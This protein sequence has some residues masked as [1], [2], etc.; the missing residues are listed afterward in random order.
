MRGLNASSRGV[1]T[2]ILSCIFD[3]LLWA[4]AF[5]FLFQMHPPNTDGHAN[6]TY[7]QDSLN[8]KD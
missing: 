1:S 6:M 5:E 4:P 8:L 3:S 2:P 7:V